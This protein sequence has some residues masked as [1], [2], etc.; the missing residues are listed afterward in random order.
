MDVKL[1]IEKGTAKNKVIRLRS[2]ETVVGRQKGSDLRI[3]SS[4]VSRRHC[5]LFFRDDYLTV[6]DLESANGTLLNGVRIAGKEVVR[7]GDR[8]EIGPVVFVVEYQLTQSAIDRLLLGPEDAAPE[9]TEEVMEAVEEV[10]E[11]EEE[12]STDPKLI[13]DKKKI[14]EDPTLAEEDTAKH[15]I[16]D[17]AESWQLPEDGELR[18]ILTHL[19]DK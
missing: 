3:P 10:E 1:V 17:D 16:L 4:Q 12:T 6:E 13:R 8:L 14:K 11:A 5:V 15:V 2:A 9:E 7:P 18:D 19:E